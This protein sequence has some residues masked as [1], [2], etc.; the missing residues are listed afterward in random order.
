MKTTNTTKNPYSDWLMGGNPTAIEK[1][2]ADGQKQFVE[3]LQLPLKTNSP[4]K[5]NTVEQYQK[6]GIKTLVPSKGDDLFIG[7]TL[8]KG[9]KKE[10]TDHSMWSNLLDDKGRIRATIFYKAAFYD[11]EAFI[12]FE[13]RY[14][15]TSEYLG[16][17]NCELP[18]T[19]LYCVK[20]T[21]SKEILFQTETTNEY[22]C[23]NLEQACIDFLETNFPDY[24]DLNAYWD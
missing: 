14:I 2:E 8:P 22:S 12:N 10:E 5:T 19:K 9:W 20:D 7:V 1:Q 15:N 24:K 16:D 11:R 4:R 17:E 6:M 21:V 18:Y 3:S 23:S 13:P